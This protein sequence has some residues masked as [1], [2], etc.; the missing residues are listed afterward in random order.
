MNKDT[1]WWRHQSVES[2]CHGNNRMLTLQV[3]YF[4]RHLQGTHSP[5]NHVAMAAYI[6]GDGGPIVTRAREIWRHIL[7]RIK[8]SLSIIQ[9]SY[10]TRTL[11]LFK[12]R[13]APRAQSALRS[14]DWPH[15]ISEQCDRSTSNGDEVTKYTAS[16]RIMRALCRIRKYTVIC[17]T[18]WT[19]H[20]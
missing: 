16:D 2:K 15:R 18:A 3:L 4:E 17:I 12:G 1:L 19:S 9:V 7:K 20:L 13:T 6:Q 8:Y 11:A 10:V 5:S 14:A